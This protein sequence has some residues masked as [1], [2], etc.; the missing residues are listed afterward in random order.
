MN[1][2]KYQ[3]EF[4]MKCSTT[5]LF[6]YIGT[7]S[8]MSEWLA[9]DVIER[10]D[11][12]TFVWGDQE[13]S[14]NLIRYKEESFVRFRWEEDEGTKYFWELAIHVDDV[15]S[16]VALVITDFAEESDLEHSKLYW[17]NLIEDLKKIIGS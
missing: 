15:T 9:D 12:F 16:D 3:L 14:A 4:A 11:K 7:S 13:E 8:G 5:L 2:I 10:G 6:E 17:E 1:K